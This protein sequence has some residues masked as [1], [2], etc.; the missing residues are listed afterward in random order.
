MN[1][2]ELKAECQ[3]RGFSTGS[4]R[5]NSLELGASDVI[6]IHAH[7]GRWEVF[8]TERGQIDLHKSFESEGE[9]ADY[10]LELC[11]RAF[12]QARS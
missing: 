11:K 6:C 1:I 10:F 3:L 12:P 7:E 8:Y 5:F 9:A 2:D 4:L